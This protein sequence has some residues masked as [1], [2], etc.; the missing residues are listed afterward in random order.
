MADIQAVLFDMGGT[1]ED[2]YYD[3]ALRLEA[4]RG[5][6]EILAKYELDPGL[7]IPDLYAVVKA[8]MRKYNALR[9]ETEIELT[10]ERVWS[11]F[12]FPDCGLNKKRLVAAS[13]EIAFYYDLDFYKRTLR[14]EA[15]ALL[16]A[17][18]ERGFRLGVISNIYSRGA[19]PHNLTRYALMEY[20][21]VVLASSVFGW[22]K[23]NTRIFLEASRLLGLSP[24]ACAYV[25]DTVSRDVVGAHR[26]G[27]RL[28]IQIKSFLTTVADKKTDTELPDAIVENLMQVVDI[29]TRSE[30]SQ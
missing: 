10:P 20:F 30:S 11:E 25:G 18:R 12:V 22:R 15:K 9:E 21:E 24:S 28:A 16:D 6:K 5:L 14:P 19:V 3:D 8:G 7:E 27:Y 23:P 4:T 1:L 2:V 26:A 29:V 13:E 17:L